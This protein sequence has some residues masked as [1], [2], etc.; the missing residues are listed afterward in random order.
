M[1][2]CVCVCIIVLVIRRA[3]RISFLRRI[4]LLPVACLAYH[5]FPRYLI[6]GTIFGDRLLLNIMCLF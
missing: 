1:N 3:N 4:I 5:I 2:V 6:N